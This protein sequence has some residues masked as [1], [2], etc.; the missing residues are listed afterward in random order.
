MR[1]G[2]KEGGRRGRERE[3]EGRRE[4]GRER[5]QLYSTCC[6]MYSTLPGRSE[7]ESP[8]LGT[9]QN[10]P[11]D[12]PENC[13]REHTLHHNTATCTTTLPLQSIINIHLTTHNKLCNIIMTAYAS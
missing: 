13:E 9:W 1:E 12:C 4:G 7:I 8:R 11:L 10:T 2:E 6:I 3:N 5:A